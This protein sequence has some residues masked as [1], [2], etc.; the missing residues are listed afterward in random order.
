MEKIDVTPYPTTSLPIS[1]RPTEDPEAGLLVKLGHTDPLWKLVKA[2]YATLN[3]THPEATKSCWLCYNLI[4]PYYE[5]VGLNASYDLANGTDPPQ[6]RWGERK[7]G[8]TMRE[9]WGKGLCMGEILSGRSPLCAHVVEPTDLPIAR[10]LIPQMGGW[11][12]CSHT[13]LTPCVHSSIFDP[14]EEFCVMV[15]VVPKILY[16][17]EETIYDYWA[18]RLTLS[19]QERTYR[20]KREP[21]TTITIATMFGLEIARAGTGITALS[22]QSQGFNSLRAAIDE[23]IT[24]IEQSISHLESSLTS[25][26]EVVLQNRRGLDLLFL[27]QGGLCAALGEECCFY[28]DHTGIVRESM[29]KVREVLAQCKQER[30]AQQGWFESWFQQSPW[31]TTLI[32]TLLG[33]LLVLLLMLAFGPCIISRL[34]AFVKERINTVQLFVLRQQYQAVSQ[35][36]EEDSSI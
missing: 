36:Q 14:K 31:L 23:D 5:A 26:S 8:L 24:R 22:L 25:L 11:W 18:Q 33:P 17:P 4:P 7:V 28:A 32:S 30:E 9:V 13:G 20:V 16:R 15:A 2:A 12:V 1:Q 29:A 21:I 19:S 10:W 27:Q 35:N 6:C 34:I 3:Q